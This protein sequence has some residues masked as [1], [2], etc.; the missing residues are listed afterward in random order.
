MEKTCIR[1]NCALQVQFVAPSSIR[2]A[3]RVLTTVYRILPQVDCI[4]NVGESCYSQLERIRKVCTKNIDVTETN[5]PN[6][7]EPKQR[8]ML[9]LTCTDGVQI[10]YGMEY[11]AIP[12]L[13]EPFIPGFKVSTRYRIVARIRYCTIY[14]RMAIFAFQIIVKGPIECR[15][16]VMLLGPQNIQVLGGESDTLLVKNAIENVL[17]RAL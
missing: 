12:F 1:E 3:P 10:L 9:K 13:N 16:G 4:L 11:T 15:R 14:S 2:N 17:A 7:W 5:K 8:R 6:P